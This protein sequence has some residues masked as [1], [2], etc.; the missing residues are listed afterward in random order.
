MATNGFCEAHACRRLRTAGWVFAAQRP[1]TH[2]LHQCYSGTEHSHFAANKP[3]C[4]GAGRMETLLGYDLV[5]QAAP[6]VRPDRQ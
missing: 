6:H 4:D 1:E 3:G 5:R 2:P